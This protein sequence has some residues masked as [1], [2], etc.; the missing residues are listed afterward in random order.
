MADVCPGAPSLQPTRY[1]VDDAPAPTAPAATSQA[2][3]T[4]PAAGVAHVAGWQSSPHAPTP[5]GSHPSPGSSVP[6]PQVADGGGHPVERH[7]SLQNVASGGSQSSPGS[8]TPFPQ[9]DGMTQP[10]ASHPVGTLCPV[11]THATRVWVLT[12]L[13]ASETTRCRSRPS[14]RTRQQT[15]A[16]GHPQTDSF[17]C[18]SVSRRQPRDNSA[19]PTRAFT[20]S[21]AQRR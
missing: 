21:V 7:W 18:F 15:A 19:E 14:A 16:P 5:G 2:T 8:T 17:A 6:L 12:H 10:V 3:T 11:L 20:T 13:A 9:T 4:S 1:F